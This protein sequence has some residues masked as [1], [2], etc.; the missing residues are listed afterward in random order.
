MPRKS[1][2]D[3]PRILPVLAGICKIVG[4]VAIVIAN[5]MRDC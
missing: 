1:K 3:G 4:A 5:W 2:D